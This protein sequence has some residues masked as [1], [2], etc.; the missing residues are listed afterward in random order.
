LCIKL[1]KYIHFP[2]LPFSRRTH[3]VKKPP[4]SGFPWHP[5]SLGEQILKKRLETGLTQ[6]EIAEQLDLNDQTISRWE[7]GENSPNIK[8]YQ[9]IMLFL[10]LHP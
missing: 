6:Q 3:L 1:Q 10:D 7:T 9:R 5:K 8:N 4:I 2:A